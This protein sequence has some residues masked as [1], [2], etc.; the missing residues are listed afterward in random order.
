MPGVASA[1]TVIKTGRLGKKARPFRKRAS[2]LLRLLVDIKGS[3]HMPNGVRH[4]VGFHLAKVL[5]F[6]TKTPN[7]VIMAIEDAVIELLT[8]QGSI[9]GIPVAL[10]PRF[11]DCR[12]VKRILQMVSMWDP[13]LRLCKTQLLHYKRQQ[14]AL[15]EREREE[16]VT[17]NSPREEMP[18]PSSW[19]QC[20]ADPLW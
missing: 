2:L 1:R 17:A 10:F 11:G 19:G 3:G 13:D 18:L 4:V 7:H 16:W 5:F 8:V 14:M 9:G 12:E 15:G 6:S 20:D